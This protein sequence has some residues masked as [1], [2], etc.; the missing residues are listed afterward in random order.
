M[1]VFTVRRILAVSAAACLLLTG[2]GSDSSSSTNLDDITVN[3][4]DNPKVKVGKDFS[5]K[6]TEKRVVTEGDGDPVAGGDSVKV[7]YV[8]VNG[9][10]GKQFDNS[11]T[12]KSPLTVTLDEKSALPGFVKA[13]SGQVVG[14]RVLVAIPPKDGFG[15]A[16]DQLGIK[17]TDTMVFLFDIVAKVPSEASGEAKNLPK[18]VPDIVEKDGQPASFKATKDTPDKVS[19]A[20]AHVAIEGDGPAVEK[21]Q[22]LSVQYLGQ[23]YPDGEIFDSSWE[24]GAPANLGLDQ[25]IKCWQDLIPGQ[26]IG[27]RVVLVCPADTA[28]GDKPQPGS[29]IKPGDTLMFAIDLLDA[30]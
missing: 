18:D 29:P 10:T 23:V 17:A 21:G 12:S 3:G 16:N 8:A 26:K 4:G 15:E 28:Y 27:S 13:L 1:K 14:S 2:C 20:S 22:S 24:R 11:F 19:K 5:T 6:S 9:R 7:N 25:V 30:S